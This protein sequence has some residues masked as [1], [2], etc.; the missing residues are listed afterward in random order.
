[1]N[2]TGFLSFAK[3]KINTPLHSDAKFRKAESPPSPKRDP[4]SDSIPSV[5]SPALSTPPHARLSSIDFH[6]AHS[7]E[8]VPCSVFRSRGTLRLV[9]EVD[10]FFL[11][12]VSQEP[13]FAE[14]I[15]PQA[16]LLQSPSSLF[17]LFLGQGSATPSAILLH[18]PLPGLLQSFVLFRVSARQKEKRC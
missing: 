13:P 5:A 18:R 3:C 8:A 17:V 10:C 7:L 9:S 16:P 11:T 1:M 12:P 4:S 6:E 2:P 15:P 14:F